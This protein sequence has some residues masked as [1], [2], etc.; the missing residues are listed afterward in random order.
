MKKRSLSICF[1]FHRSIVSL[2]LCKS[3]KFHSL[4]FQSSSFAMARKF[5]GAKL[6]SQKRSFILSY[7]E[8]QDLGLNQVK[9][10]A[11]DL[12]ETTT[13]LKNIWS[14]FLLSCFAF[15]FP[16]PSPLQRTS[17]WI[18]NEPWC[19]RQRW[20]SSSC[21]SIA[22]SGLSTWLL[23]VLVAEV[24][25]KVRRGRRDVDCDGLARLV[26]F[27]AKGR[28][29]ALERRYADYSQ[30]FGSAGRAPHLMGKERKK[31]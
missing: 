29:C 24:R 12:D 21:R 2:V 6:G 5:V 11:V 7:L 15:E 28:V 25:Q 20:P 9:G 13:S 19:G 4:K 30:S 22:R 14:A 18:S 16:P 10:L 31:E 23:I 27:F 17:P 26:D 3:P 1:S 8:A